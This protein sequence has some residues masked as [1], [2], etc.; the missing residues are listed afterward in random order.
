MD[1]TGSGLICAIGSVKYSKVC[2]G[3]CHI[4]LWRGGRFIVRMSFM[5]SL[6]V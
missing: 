4:H 3:P 5:D 2:V 6:L 1:G